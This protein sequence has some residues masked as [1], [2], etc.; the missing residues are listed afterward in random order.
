MSA[1]DGFSKLEITGVPQQEGFSIKL[2]GHE[3][4][5]VRGI[6]LVMQTDD[7]PTA[8]IDLYLGDVEIDSEFMVFL[9]GRIK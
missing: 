2:D 3:L 6:E 8:T 7:L 1:R 9:E 4:Y 5:G